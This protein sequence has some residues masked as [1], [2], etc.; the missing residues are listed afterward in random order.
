MGKVNLLIVEPNDEDLDSISSCFDQ[1]KYTISYTDNGADAVSI[2]QKCPPD[3]I[4]LDTEARSISG[5]EVCRQLRRM[6]STAKIPIILLAGRKNEDDLVASLKMGADDYVVKP[7]RPLELVARVSAVLRRVRHSS[8]CERMV[9]A[10]VEID[11]LSHK[12]R[13]N[14]R[15][16]KL[17]SK[18]F[19]LL[20][21]LMANPAFVHSR[22]HLLQTVWEDNRDVDTRTVDVYIRRLRQAI[23]ANGYPDVIRTIRSVGY[24]MNTDI[25]E[26]TP[27]DPHH[28]AIAVSSRGTY[29][30]NADEMAAVDNGTEL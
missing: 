5:L 28:H 23:N 6:P 29:V 30:G 26:A 24:A 2:S 10:D 21:R 15:L 1:E 25:E 18:E 12:V 14:G 7:V 19:G 3:L 22:D 9:F 16:I 13:R 4:L 27:P 8:L 20:C 11:L 17:G